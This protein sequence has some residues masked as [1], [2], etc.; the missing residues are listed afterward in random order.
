[1]Q[2]STAFILLALLVC[3]CQQVASLAIDVQANSQE[4]FFEELDPGDKMTIT[5]QVR[6][7]YDLVKPVTGI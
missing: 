3:L 1:M 6:L 2:H 5:F 4:C 7:V